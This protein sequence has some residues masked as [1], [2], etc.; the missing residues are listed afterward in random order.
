MPMHPDFPTDPHVVIPPHVR[1][2]PGGERLSG[3]TD[4]ASLLPPLVGTIR[5]RVHDWRASGYP[6]A[7]ETSVALLQHWF[8][9]FHLLEAGDGTTTEFGYYFAQREAVETAIWLYEVEKAHDPYSL[10][11]YDASGRVSMSMFVAHW[12]RYVFKLATGSGKTKVLSLLIAWSY[13][14]KTYENDSPLS[15]NFVLVAPN[16]IVLD[17]LLDDF[18]GL[19]IFRTDPVLPPNGFAGRDWEDDFQV[20]LHVQDDI[21]HVSKTGNLFLTNIHR[22]YDSPP[23][24]S[25]SDENLTDYFLGARPTGRARDNRVDLGAVIRELSDLV[26]L[27]DEAHHIHDVD[28][29]WFRAIEDIENRLKQ[30]GGGIAVQLD[31]TAT[32]KH[33]SGAIFVDTVC[34]YPLVEAIKQG[35]VKTPVVPDAESRRRLR[36]GSSDRVAERYA[37]HI[38]LGY[39]EW[40]KKYDEFAR[41]GKKAVLFVM[42]SDTKE[43]NEVAAHLERAFPDLD[44]KV[45]VIHTKA[46][47]FISESESKRAEL[48]RLRK[49][50]AE[51]DD[52][53]SPYLA[54]VSVLM[55]REGWDV[56]NVVAMV[57]LRPFGQQ[58]KILPEQTLGRGLRRMFRGDP[59]LTEYVSIV[60]TDTFMDFVQEISE[61]G[62][63][64]EQ[65]PMGPESTPRQPLVVEV[66]TNAPEKNID[67]LDIQLPVLTPRVAREYRNLADLDVSRMP[68]CRLPLR[69]FSPEE[70]RII[71]F[72]EAVDGEAVV[73]TTD[74]GKDVLPT[75]QAVV[76]FLTN[77]LVA[78]MRLVG[79]KDIVYERMR[80]YIRDY[81]FESSVDLGEPTVLKNLT[82]T[83]VQRSLFM[84]L[85]AAINELTVETSESTSIAD[86]LAF[87]R[88]RPHVVSHQSFIVPKKSLFNRVVGDSRLELLF[89]AFLDECDDIQSFVKNSRST[90]FKIEYITQGGTIANYYPDFVVK[91]SE[92][93]CW[94]VETKGNEDLDVEPKWQRLVQWCEDA[95]SL[96]VMGRTFKAMFVSEHE[97]LR[98]RP[99]GFAEAISFFEGARP[100]QQVRMN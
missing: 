76:S 18:Q 48:D 79:G 83:G 69:E 26:V 16:I 99:R 74:L 41:V 55:L 52:P 45:L 65:V 63:E 80:D 40:R 51:I 25:R 53:S 54:V 66:D 43:S 37:D 91:Q 22:V 28:L 42:T 67:Y 6:G 32:P 98:N 38:K 72:K 46:N 75:P 62:V 9:G 47:G 86:T 1:W 11:R 17:R 20:S 49:A 84:V 4:P 92:S 87:S 24:A 44:G 70:A 3:G 59:E 5:V 94:I 19:S 50:A 88:T 56:K 15:T 29:A 73:W 64:L 7:S 33:G 97:F 10:L 77:L 2:H 82:D 39:L 30:K 27:N 89:A 60:G 61:E 23:P 35:V 78:E 12:P 100:A 31:L 85:K 58:A 57:G 21:G 95:T 14:H 68:Q 13:F 90:H 71:A 34:S 96:D 8:S 93:E 36:E 81:L